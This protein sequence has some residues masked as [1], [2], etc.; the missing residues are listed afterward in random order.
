MYCYITLPCNFR[1][2]SLT[3][4]WSRSHSGVNVTRDLGLITID[5]VN[6]DALGPNHTLSVTAC[7]INGF[8]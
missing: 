8:L 4:F 2:L 7:V 6:G 3:V 1:Y 5:F